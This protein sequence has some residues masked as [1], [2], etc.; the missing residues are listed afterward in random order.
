MSNHNKSEKNETA[1]KTLV[2]KKSPSVRWAWV[3]ILDALPSY[4]H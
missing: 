3:K 2:V 1:E 4:H